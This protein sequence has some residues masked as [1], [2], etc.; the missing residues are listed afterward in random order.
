MN[1]ENMSPFLPQSDISLSLQPNEPPSSP[2]VSNS[3]LYN[4]P[5][6]TLG[7]PTTSTASGSLDVLPSP[8]KRSAIASLNKPLSHEQAQQLQSL[9]AAQVVPTS[10]L[11]LSSRSTSR[12]PANLDAPGGLPTPPSSSEALTTTPRAPNQAL[13]ALPREPVSPSPSRTRTAV[14]SPARASPSRPSRSA[15]TPRSALRSSS[16]RRTLG[17]DGDSNSDDEDGNFLRSSDDHT[18]KRMQPLRE[19]D[20]ASG[21]D[22]DDDDEDDEE[23]D[24]IKLISFTRRGPDAT[25]LR[26]IKENGWD[27][28]MPPS[29][30]KFTYLEPAAPR[31]PRQSSVGARARSQSRSKTPQIRASPAP[32]HAS[33]SRASQPSR[34]VRAS[35]VAATAAADDTN[36]ASDESI[37]SSGTALTHASRVSQA[38][39]IKSSASRRSARSSVAPPVVVADLT[40]D[41]PSLPDSPGDDPLLLVGPDTYIVY[42]DQTPSA[43]NR[44]TAR[45][46]KAATAHAD[47][48]VSTLSHSTP[49][50]VAADAAGKAASERRESNASLSS[51]ASRSSLYTRMSGRQP[52][53]A[54]VGALDNEDDQDDEESRRTENANATQTWADGMDEAEQQHGQDGAVFLPFDDAGFASDSD[55]DEADPLEPP[56]SPPAQGAD[57]DLDDMAS[58]SDVSRSFAD[59]SAA[60]HRSEIT[61]PV[62]VSAADSSLEQD[63]SA[64]VDQ[65]LHVGFVDQ[66]MDESAQDESHD[67]I[68]D[69]SRGGDQTMDKSA[70]ET[71]ADI[72]ENVTN[73]AAEE[74]GE[75][76]SQD[77][78]RAF[79]TSQPSLTASVRDVSADV[80]AVEDSADISAAVDRSVDVS[81]DDQPTDVTADDSS[82]SLRNG[83]QNMDVSESIE[84]VSMAVSDAVQVDETQDD[85]EVAD[86]TD[87][88]NEG[89]AG[90]TSVLA[91]ATVDSEAAQSSD[92]S[93]LS[94][95]LSEGR[96]HG[97]E[98]Q[99]VDAADD[100]QGAGPLE[101]D[102]TNGTSDQDESMVADP[103]AAADDSIV[104]ISRL[105]NDQAPST[106]APLLDG[107]LLP[108]PIVLLDTLPADS[109][110][111]I[112]WKAH[113]LKT[114][115]STSNH[116]VSTAST[117]DIDISVRNPDSTADASV[118]MVDREGEMPRSESMASVASVLSSVSL[119]DAVGDEDEEAI[120]R[121]YQ[122][123]RESAAA[124]RITLSRR[125]SLSTDSEHES[126]A[127]EE[128]GE[129]LQDAEQS[130][131]QGI[132]AMRSRVDSQAG[133]DEEDDVEEDDD[134]EEEEEEDL[135]DAE[136]AISDEAAS[137]E[138]EQD[139][140]E[141]SEEES[142]DLSSGEED[143]VDE[144][145][146][147][148]LDQHEHS[149]SLLDPVV[150]ISSSASPSAASTA[151]LPSNDDAEADES[152]V[153]SVVRDP[154]DRSINLSEHSV[155]P[156]SP[157]IHTLHLRQPGLDD[158]RPTS[159]TL[160]GD[161]SHSRSRVLKLTQAT[162]TPIVEISSLD[163]RAAARATAILKLFHKY[164]DE[165]WISGGLEMGETTR[166]R[167]GRVVEAIERAD[168]EGEEDLTRLLMDAELELARPA[169][170]EESFLG[171]RAT[172]VVGGEPSTPFLPGGFRATPAA[173]GGKRTSF[174]F[175]GLATPDGSNRSVARQARL[176]AALAP[177]SASAFDPRVWDTQDWV[178]LDKYFTLGVRKIS[179][180]LIASHPSSGDSRAAKARCY[181]EALQG[182]DV[183]EVSNMFFTE[184]GVAEGARVDE[185]AV[186]KVECRVGVL[187][188]KYLRKVESKYA[189]VVGE[190]LGEE[191][192]ESLPTGDLDWSLTAADST[193]TVAAGERRGR[194]SFGTPYRMGAHSTPA[195][196]L[197][198]K[199]TATAAEKQGRLYPTLPT[200]TLT[201]TTA[202]TEAE[203]VMGRAS[204]LI[205]RISGS[206]GGLL[207]SPRV[208][209]GKRKASEAQLDASSACETRRRRVDD[210]EEEEEESSETHSALFASGRGASTINASMFTEATSVAD[211]SHRPTSK[212]SAVRPTPIHPRSQPSSSSSSSTL[213]RPLP[214][215]NTS[216]TTR[217]MASA[218]PSR[219][220][221]F[222]SSRQ[223]A[224]GSSGV[225]H[226]PLS[227][228][229]PATHR[230][231]A[232]KVD[233]LRQ[234]R[235]QRNWTSPR[236]QLTMAR[237]RNTVG[238][239]RDTR[240]VRHPR[241]GDS[242]GG[243]GSGASSSSLS[244]DG[245]LSLA[246]IV[247]SSAA[248]DAVRGNRRRG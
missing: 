84:D 14:L 194:V 113:Q 76:D 189:G 12:L 129:D 199:A 248:R 148:Q 11:S 156:D 124:R 110:A 216:S 46:S 191:G 36:D 21:E 42:H 43:K 179:S 158:T 217:P 173:K 134:E 96:E 161:T 197:L 9:R 231:A 202:E 174:G 85:S 176:S 121:K 2:L 170:E 193:T 144:D 160:G 28:P 155:L 221:T 101:H 225:S 22:Q 98:S 237:T 4:L 196:G 139:S 154:R 37:K 30:I 116:D 222:T 65:S 48:S 81:L 106:A 25:F 26:E 135:D 213:T 99:A 6:P 140:E 104:D 15:S 118:S 8:Y 102:L 152:Y 210:S 64:I 159:T 127:E 100:S 27:Q 95:A 97:D 238:G 45:A 230:V 190:R 192:E 150:I 169:E 60:H 247:M 241:G 232:R 186:E 163:P 44:S 138:E 132:T 47:A 133:Q 123:S 203:G 226:T 35:S 82:A 204:K 40:R 90:E 224:G 175:P 233:E 38:R 115:S 39:S 141:A 23:E 240:E 218:P 55:Q 87:D 32:S 83:G 208:S 29:P 164:V 185:W 236:R 92:L 108:K 114:N 165:G 111:I 223:L 66:S 162:S 229:S 68:A 117:F 86:N 205:S 198:R 219:S 17:A 53:N 80:E 201:D 126:D 7:I 180:S 168:L 137:S 206:F 119:V 89:G 157:H 181:V 243:D 51:S 107:S 215:T 195:V 5:D 167:L 77:A 188:R 136:S 56:A 41:H 69:D 143:D 228:L 245:S 73:D 239:V 172:S 67:S 178:R 145:A 13:S 235:A 146:S 130:S 211:T 182:L 128:D 16:S 183:V 246:E 75:E 125:L 209:E 109:S 3:F 1:D 10:A 54:D 59:D 105:A 57:Q 122:S 62:D 234:S 58:M 177:P 72:S 244:S 78:S 79:D 19:L 49:L 187:Q 171:S 147:S 50:P 220:H 93:S 91:D 112:S 131:L 33:T 61:G 142:D 207:A 88:T 242:S 34:S 212:S 74:G 103:Q 184:M 70:A 214:S 227:L 18:P 153:I 63:D 71:S 94:S 52:V 151:S 120:R 149:A 166:G 31:P 20:E 24:E 200:S